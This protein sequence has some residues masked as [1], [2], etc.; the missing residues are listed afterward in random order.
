MNV[1]TNIKDASQVLKPKTAVIGNFDGVHSGH[2]KLIGKALKYEGPFLIITFD[3]HPAIFFDP[4]KKVSL[5]TTKKDKTDLLI[6][7]GA[8]GI[9]EIPF[10]ENFSE[11]STVEFMD[12]MVSKLK[13]KNLLVGERFRFGKNRKGDSDLLKSFLNKKGINVQIVSTHKIGGK[14]VSSTRIRTLINEGYIVE[15][16]KL[17]NRMFRISGVVRKGLGI[18]KKLGYSTANFESE[19][20]IPGTGVYAGYCT[21]DGKEYS[22][23]LSCGNRKT[24]GNYPVEIEI[25]LIDFSEEIYGKHIQ[26][27][28]FSKIREQIKFAGIEQLKDQI[29]KDIESVKIVLSKN[30]RILK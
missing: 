15:A 25:H 17:L 23:A 13:I 22:G 7:N 16:N 24:I 27:E 11:M 26:F 18:G 14:P 8:K 2:V 9:L 10:T 30:V 20:L 29:K 12:I 5:L 28:F 6:K 4:A 3:P 1:F 19:Q 21:V